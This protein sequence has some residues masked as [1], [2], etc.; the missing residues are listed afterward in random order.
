MATR[1][2]EE[3]SNPRSVSLEH[4]VEAV[5]IP[6]HWA[7]TYFIIKNVCMNRFLHNLVISVHLIN[8]FSFGKRLLAT[9]YSMGFD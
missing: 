7:N 3:P 9:A 2:N 6:T 5:L 1:T 8:A 4:A